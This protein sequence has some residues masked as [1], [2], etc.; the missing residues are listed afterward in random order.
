MLTSNFCISNDEL[1][2]AAAFSSS[3][4][5]LC[6]FFPVVLLAWLSELV[7]DEGARGI[8][9]LEPVASLVGQLGRDEGTS[10]SRSCAVGVTT[11]PGVGPAETEEECCTGAPGG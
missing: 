11:G 2:T 5:T 1:S 6:F 7:D 4:T 8:L 10:T 3:F 9:V